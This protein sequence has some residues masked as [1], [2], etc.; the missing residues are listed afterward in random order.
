MASTNDNRRRP[1]NRSALSQQ[2][3]KLQRTFP[4]EERLKGGK[5]SIL[6]T[7]R[8]AAD[9]RLEDIQERAQKAFENVRRK[10]SRFDAFGSKLFYTSGKGM[11][12]VEGEDKDA[13]RYQQVNHR[14]KLDAKENE[15]L[16]KV[17]RQFL[18]LFASTCGKIFGVATR[19]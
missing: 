10:D 1:N 12:N 5:A 4:N 3:S 8:D 7:A 13:E 16:N 15:K 9:V 2:L 14:E 6:H 17:I 11:L 19:I 18:R